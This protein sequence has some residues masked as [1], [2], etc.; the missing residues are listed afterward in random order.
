MDKVMITQLQDSINSSTDDLYQSESK[1]TISNQSYIF[2]RSKINPVISPNEPNYED[3]RK[4]LKFPDNPAYLR[5]NKFYKE[6]EALVPILKYCRENEI[7][8]NKADRMLYR[9]NQ[10]KD[11]YRL[12]NNCIGKLYEKDQDKRSKD[13]NSSSLLS[14][15]RR[16]Q[17]S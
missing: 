10:S 15:E 14:I 1:Q 2:E 3:L 16:D 13:K 5:I 7:P 12:F 11:N 9:I 6:K 4:R 17:S 8:F